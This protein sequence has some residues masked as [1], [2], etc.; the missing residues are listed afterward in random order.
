MSATSFAVGVAPTILTC[1]SS[2]PPELPFAWKYTAP[3]N[4]VKFVGS[5]ELELPVR[6]SS[7]SVLPLSIHRSVPAAEVLAL[8]NSACTGAADRTSSVTSP[9][10]V[11]VPS[12]TEYRK[13]E[14]LSGEA[15]FGV[16]RS[17]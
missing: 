10:S 12:L 11:L 3:L 13:R 4:D 2:V 5:D 14:T 17:P 15:G 8:K 16:K 7:V 1:H 9:S 6:S